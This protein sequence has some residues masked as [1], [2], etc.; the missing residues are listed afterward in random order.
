[1]SK[2]SK[3][4]IA[5]RG[6]IASRIIRTAREMDIATVAVYSDADRDAPY[7]SE[8][9]EA[10]HLPGH[11]RRLTPICVP[12]W[13]SPPRLAPTPK[14]STPATDSF[15]RTLISRGPAPKPGSSSS[16]PARRPSPRWAPRSP[17]RT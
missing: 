4:L 7:V 1:M 16:D 12:T 3:L 6:E 5:N 13:C 14:P 11:R 10:V 15:R 2:I 8:A 17:P 9:D